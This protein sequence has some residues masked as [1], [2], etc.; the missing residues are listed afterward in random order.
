MKFI[1]SYSKLQKCVSKTGIRGTWNEIENHQIQYRTDDRAVLNWW[2]ST[3]TVTF[4][5]R[6]S[7]A[8]RFS[9][10]FVR[11]A[12]RRNLLEDEADPGHEIAEFESQL[13]AALV[14]I[15]ELKKAVQIGDARR[16]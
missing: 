14:D 6:K 5:G 1:A 3:R 13:K 10:A 4:Q 2:E 11:V 12:S 16:R 7:A 8:Q 9:K 15:A